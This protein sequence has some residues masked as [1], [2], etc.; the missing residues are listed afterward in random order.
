[1]EED[2]EHWCELLQLNQPGHNRAKCASFVIDS[3]QNTHNGDIVETPHQYYQQPQP[4]L[5]QK[6]SS[7]DEQT[8]FQYKP[9][10]PPPPPPSQ[11]EGSRTPPST[12]Y[13]QATRK[14]HP[15]NSDLNYFSCYPIVFRG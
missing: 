5:F 4:V 11:V 15:Y 3:Q 13:V 7:M 9:D 10:L 6:I 2:I 14:D 1:M 12:V 8:I